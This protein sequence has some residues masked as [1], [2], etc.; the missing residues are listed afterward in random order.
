MNNSQLFPVTGRDV[1]IAAGAALVVGGLLLVWDK[2]FRP[3]KAVPMTPAPAPSPVE[4]QPNWEEISDCIS[5]LRQEMVEVKAE[6]RN[7]KR[8][9]WMWRILQIAILL[10]P[11]A[12]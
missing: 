4:H 2:Y 5:C 3:P 12:V 8:W 1:A 6:M 10:A 9:E 11:L 7:G